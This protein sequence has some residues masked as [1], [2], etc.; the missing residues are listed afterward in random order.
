MATILDLSYVLTEVIDETIPTPSSSGPSR[1][2]KPKHR[3]A[4]AWS[5]FSG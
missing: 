1:L 2:S 4:P 5:M 3:N